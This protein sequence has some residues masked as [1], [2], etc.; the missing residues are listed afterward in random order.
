MKFAA[1]SVIQIWAFGFPFGF[2]VSSF[3]FHF[4]DSGFS[5]CRSCYKSLSHDQF[6]AH[7]G[8]RYLGSPPVCGLADP[9]SPLVPFFHPTINVRHRVKP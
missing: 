8:R 7:P 1:V 4:G 3:W 9:T 5:F 2:L 6:P